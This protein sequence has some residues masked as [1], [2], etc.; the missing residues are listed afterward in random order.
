FASNESMVVE[1][2]PGIDVYTYSSTTYSS[3]TSYLNSYEGKPFGSLV[4][5]AYQRDEATGQILLG[6]DNMPLYTEETHN[7]GSV[8]PDFT[9]GFFNTFAY[10]NWRLS[11]MIEFQG[12]GQ[13]FSRSKMLAVRTGQDPLTVE[14]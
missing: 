10:G 2:A 3:V 14:T 13:F 1:L 5:T 11:G 9:G 4:G 7:F 8:L 12:G 6:E